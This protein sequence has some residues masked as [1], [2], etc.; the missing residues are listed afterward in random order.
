MFTCYPLNHC[1]IERT[2]GTKRLRFDPWVGRSPGLGNGN[3]LQY[4]CLENSMDRG[5]WWAIV[6]GVAN[7]WT[8]LSDRMH[9]SMSYGVS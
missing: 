4:L 7:S 2:Q 3:L 1:S 6:H 9:T 5:S 8:R